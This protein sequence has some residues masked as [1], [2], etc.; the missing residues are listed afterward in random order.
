MDPHVEPDLTGSTVQ[1]V[2]GVLA[3]PAFRRLWAGTTL[4]SVGSAMT[5]FAIPLQVYNITRSPF[6]VGA[7]GVA[8]AVP[9]L[10]I[11]LLGGSLADVLDRRRLVLFSSVGLALISAALAVQSLAGLRLVPLQSMS[12]AQS[13]PCPCR[14]PL[15]RWPGC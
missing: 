13:G 10:A 14:R 9:T 11:G 7:I 6:A 8:T 1:R 2:R 4:S 5:S 12:P 3:I 15:R